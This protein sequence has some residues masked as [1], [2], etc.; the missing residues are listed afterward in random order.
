MRCAIPLASTNFAYLGGVYCPDRGTM[1]SLVSSSKCI[2]HPLA[3]VYLS[4]RPWEK[5][6]WARQDRG[7]VGLT[8]Q[9]FWCPAGDA[10][11]G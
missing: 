8:V 5:L 7:V 4:H 2:I 1:S 11:R 10:L 3:K 9:R 6:F